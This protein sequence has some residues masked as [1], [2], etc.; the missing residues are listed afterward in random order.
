MQ[1]RE[2]FAV[3]LHRCEGL[4]LPVQVT[5]LQCRKVPVLEAT[6][7]HWWP[8]PPL[9]PA[10][11]PAMFPGFGLTEQA[12]SALGEHMAGTE[13]FV[14]FLLLHLH[15]PKLLLVIGRQLQQARAENVEAGGSI[16]P[17]DRAWKAPPVLCKVQA[18]T[19]AGVSI[20]GFVPYLSSQSGNQRHSLYL[21]V[22]KRDLKHRFLFSSEAGVSLWLCARTLSQFPHWAAKQLPM[23]YFISLRQRR[24]AVWLQMACLRALELGKGSLTLLLPTLLFLR[25]FCFLSN[26]AVGL[27]MLAPLRCSPSLHQLPLLCYLWAFLLHGGFSWIK[28]WH[29]RLSLNSSAWAGST[30][31]RTTL[32]RPRYCIENTQK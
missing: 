7:C 10:F 18:L 4:T 3:V 5:V 6:S 14:P 26:L 30:E 19:G 16:C 32:S 27:L 15:C 12:S 20:K 2:A 22:S 21:M 25:L 11:V 13:H 17:Q 1:T 31:F 29:Q 28:N 23:F 8:V 9:R 24:R